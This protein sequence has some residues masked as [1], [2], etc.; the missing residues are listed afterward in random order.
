MF[1]KFCRWLD[2]NPGPLDRKRPLYQLS[3]NHSHSC[4]PR[5]MLYE[6][7]APMTM[8]EIDFRE[9]AWTQPSP[10][11]WG[12]DRGTT[13]SIANKNQTSN[14]WKFCP[15]WS[16]RFERYLTFS[17]AQTDKQINPVLYTDKG[18]NYFPSA[19]FLPFHSLAAWPVKSRQMS[20]KSGPKLISLEKWKILTPLTSCLK[21]GNLGK[22][23]V[24]KGLEKLP[25][26][27]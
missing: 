26:V 5:Q 20:I 9:K 19:N 6:M 1:N 27:Q 13:H 12:L 17:A 11:R 8:E 7:I 3:H 23:I 10:C 22:I 24:A 2:L 18:D 14:P 25:K 16:H 21:C 15:N 4:L